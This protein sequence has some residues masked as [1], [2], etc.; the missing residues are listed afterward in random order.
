[1][2]GLC[3]RGLTAAL[4]GVLPAVVVA[5]GTA[6]LSGKV[7]AKGSGDP[8]TGV[9]IQVAGSTL[10]TIT[11]SDGTYR[12]V[13]RA[14][15]YDLRI[16]LLG[17]TSQVDTVTIAAGRAVRRDYTLAKA[18]MQ[19]DAVAV[20]GTRADERTIT[21][22]PVPVDVISAAQ[23]AA[24]GRTETGQMIQL[25][26]PSFNFARATVQNGADFMRPATLRG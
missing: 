15:R 10:G 18:P 23:L 21:T 25:A 24:T 13:L 6:E 4:F 20:T 16:R 2:S 22:S 12:L 9:T 14:G 26:A 11:R 1:M 7:V 17:Y 5:Q 19:L 3:A 8:V